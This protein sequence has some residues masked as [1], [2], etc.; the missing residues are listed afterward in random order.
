MRRTEAFFSTLKTEAFPSE[1]VF[2]TPADARRELFEYIELYYNNLRLHS[3]LGYQTPRQYETE[4]ERV[5]DSRNG[6][7][8]VLGAASEDRAMLRTHLE[9]R[10][11]LQTAGGAALRRPAGRVEKIG[12]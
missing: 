8:E 4:F 2:A 9:R 11:A 10:A 6:S 7:P 12:G 3:S 1:Q 5:V